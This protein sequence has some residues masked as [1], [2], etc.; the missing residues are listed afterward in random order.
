MTTD[1]CQ[2]QIDSACDN[3]RPGTFSAMDGVDE[4]IC[5][6]CYFSEEFQDE[7]AEMR[8]NATRQTADWEG[9]LAQPHTGNE[10]L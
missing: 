10:D 8:W 9:E 1:R 4:V 6:A 2:R 7:L 5:E 3:H